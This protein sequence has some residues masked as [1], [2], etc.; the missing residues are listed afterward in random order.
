MPCSM[1]GTC[2]FDEKTIHL[3]FAWLPLTDMNG[4]SIW[5]ER[6]WEYG[7]RC[8]VG[9][10]VLRGRRKEYHSKDSFWRCIRCRLRGLY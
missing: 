2:K 7:A 5:L 10:F 1:L 9:F 8:Q 3:R 6:Y 4:Q